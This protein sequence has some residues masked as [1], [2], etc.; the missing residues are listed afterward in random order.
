MTAD[1]FIFC[2]PPAAVA[3]SNFITATISYTG[4]TQIEGE[5]DWGSC[6]FR[7]DPK[8]PFPI[9]SI[10]NL[11]K[12]YGNQVAN[13]LNLNIKVNHPEQPIIGSSELLENIRE[14]LNKRFKEITSL[15]LVNRIDWKKAM[16]IAQEQFVATQVA[17]QGIHNAYFAGDYLGCPAMETALRTGKRAAAQLMSDA[18]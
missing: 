1:Y 6:F 16:P 7:E 13:H 2:Q 18:N 8:L 9:L 3:Y 10:V 15:Q 17:A 4:V 5:T 12:L 11:E 14:Q